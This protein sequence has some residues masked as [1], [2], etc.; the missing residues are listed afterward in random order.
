MA[1]DKN[2]AI[3]HTGGIS[4][5]ENE[6]LARGFGPITE[7]VPIQDGTE[8]IL[9]TSKFSDSGRL[10]FSGDQQIYLEQ[11]ELIAGY[12]YVHFI[13]ARFIK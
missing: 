9:Y 6:S 8:I 7:L 13:K 5:A 12:P 10:T 3:S 11:P 1:W 4:T 2:A